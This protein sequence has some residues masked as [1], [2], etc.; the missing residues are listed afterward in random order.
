[1]SAPNAMK[2][3]V[4]TGFSSPAAGFDQ[5]FEML[6]ACHE[7]VQ[8]SLGLLGRIVEHIDTHGHDAQS[9]SASADVQRYFDLA[10]PHHHEDEERHVF[11]LLL[12]SDAVGA[13]V[14]EAVRRLQLEHDRM[15]AEWQPLRQMLQRWQGDGPVPPTAD[16]RARIAAFDALYAGHIALEESVVYPAAQRLL[17]GDALAAAGEEMRARRQGPA[18]GKG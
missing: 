17:Q 10:G 1:M 14:H 12:A 13:Q 5:P 11:P 16:E 4:F 8:R 9:R 7:R 18:G 2:Q 3:P 6:T 15:H